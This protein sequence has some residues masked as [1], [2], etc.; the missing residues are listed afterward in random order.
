MRLIG[1]ATLAFVA[2]GLQGCLS[3]PDTFGDM[4]QRLDSVAVPGDFT[5][6]GKEQQ[7]MRS[8]FMASPEPTVANKYSVRWDQGML[9]DRLRDLLNE[10]GWIVRESGSGTC[11]FKTGTTA[12]PRAWLVNVWR[13][14]LEAYARAP[15]IVTTFSDERC[16]EIRE[17]HERD[18]GPKNYYHRYEDC[19]VAPS[20][21]FVSI[22]VHG[23]TDW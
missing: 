12:G 17:R 7:G 5:L 13:Y 10:H 15:D 21:A 23:E 6:I 20:E 16:A 22:V 11:G 3:L 14:E 8:S 4:W 1:L 9:C 18:H 2:L 19:W